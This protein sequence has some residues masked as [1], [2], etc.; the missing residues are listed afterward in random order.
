M[1]FPEAAARSLLRLRPDKPP[2]QEPEIKRAKK[3]WGLAEQS[4]SY[5]TNRDEISQSEP[6]TLSLPT[7]QNFLKVELRPRQ[8]DALNTWESANRQGIL[9]MATG[10]GK[11]IT[12][13]ACAASVKDLDFIV[14]GAP[15]NEIVQQWVDELAH[16]TTFRTPLIA[17]GGA[18]LWMEPLFRKLRLIHSGQL[19]RERLPVVVVGSYSELSKSRIDNLIDDAGGLPQHSLLIADEVH[20]TGAAVF[21]RILRNDFQF[22]LG[23]SATPVRLYDEEGTELVL[24]YF[25]G[26]VYEFTLEQA[27]AAGILCEYEYHVYVTQLTA[28]EYVRFQN[29]T[30]KIARLY[31]SDEEDAIAQAKLLSIQRANLIKSAASKLAVLNHILSDHPPR[32]GMIYCADITQATRVS[33]LSNLHLLVVAPNF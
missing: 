33:G 26:V 21:R 27:I 4:G 10:A 14:I 20:A 8:V 23:L 17:T 30:T 15:T 29:L 12:G 5:R 25:G 24:E 13:L 22:R 11:T 19:P 2:E 18:E 9:A 1:G 31:N 3:Y 32:R 7:F 28:S 16:R 6:E